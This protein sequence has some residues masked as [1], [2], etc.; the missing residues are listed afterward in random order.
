MSFDYK[1]AH[2]LEGKSYCHRGRRQLGAE[3]C[4]GLRAMGASFF[5]NRCR[6]RKGQAIV[7]NDRSR[8]DR[9]FP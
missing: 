6:R 8:C 7:K 3:I 1:S 2:S 9:S 5:G 4:R